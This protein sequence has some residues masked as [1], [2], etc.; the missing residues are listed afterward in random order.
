MSMK[1]LN[2]KPSKKT[3]KNSLPNSEERKMDPILQGQLITG[4]VYGLICGG[5]D[6]SMLLSCRVGVGRA[7]VS[8]SSLR[9]SRAVVMCH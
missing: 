4:A 1:L 5:G 2:L 8:C 3:R 6:L 9:E 7:L